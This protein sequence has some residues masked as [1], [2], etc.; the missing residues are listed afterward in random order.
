MVHN[1]ASVD[2][3][4]ATPSN[5]D[6]L[7]SVRQVNKY[8]GDFQ[9][10]KDID[11]DVHRGEVVAVIGASGSGKS[12][13]CRCI[14]RLETISDGEI[15]IDGEPLPEEGKSSSPSTSSRT[16]VPWRT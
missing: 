16:C 10:L 5:E 4:S 7:I 3:G 1:S 8:F 14:N 15:L 9:A 11:L 6:P 13:L 12:T 2:E